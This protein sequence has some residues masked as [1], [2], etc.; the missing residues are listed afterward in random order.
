EQKEIENE[1]LSEVSL[2]LLESLNS[3]K[4]TSKTF[5]ELENFIKSISEYSF[6]RSL[7]IS[8]YFIQNAVT[9]YQST[10]H[11]DVA[12]KKIFDATLFSA[13]IVGYLS[14][15]YIKTELKY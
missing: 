4:L 15:K 3:N 5:K 1:E 8:T 9:R 12:I 13:H 7:P 11:A 10:P 2:M 14:R 6:N